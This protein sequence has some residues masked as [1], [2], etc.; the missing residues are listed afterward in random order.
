V[1]EGMPEGGG[2]ADGDGRGARREV[3]GLDHRGVAVRTAEA[4]LWAE[5]SPAA[6][7]RRWE[8]SRRTTRSP[9]RF[10]RTANGERARSLA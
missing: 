3:T 7:S 2:V 9:E 4:A 1:N 5:S 8:R 6:L 10:R